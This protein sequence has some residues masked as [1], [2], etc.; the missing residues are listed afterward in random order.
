MRRRNP[1]WGTIGGLAMRGP[2]IR[3][4]GLG[5]A[6]STGLLWHVMLAVGA[7]VGTER[8]QLHHL[9]RVILVRRS[10][11][12]PGAVQPQEHRRILRDVEQELLERAE[13]VGAEEPVLT[14]HQ[15]LIADSIV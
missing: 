2:S 6:S 9:A 1:A 3:S 13:P 4:G 8:E 10:L 15:R 5:I 12:V 7:A 14:E 11:D